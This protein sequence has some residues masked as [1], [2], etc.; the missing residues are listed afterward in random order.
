MREPALLILAYCP[1]W[2]PSSLPWVLSAAARLET[3]TL[4][5]GGRRREFRREPAVEE[6]QSAPTRNRVE[7][8]SHILCGRALVRP[9][10][11]K[12]SS[13]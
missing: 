2:S 6:D 1:R 10:P 4:H 3:V 11:M 12:S 9:E 5:L 13:R 7:K 8:P